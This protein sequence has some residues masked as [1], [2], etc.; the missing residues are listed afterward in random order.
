MNPSS[1]KRVI[2][3]YDGKC[4]FC[5]SVASHYRKVKGHEKVLF[6]NI[7][8]KKFNS[9]RQGLSKKEAEEVIHA[10]LPNG[11]MKLGVDALITLW[12]TFP[13]YKIFAKVFNHSATKPIAQVFYRIIAKYR[14]QIPKFLLR[15]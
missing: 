8:T 4:G 9:Y 14:K 6:I 11:Q 15:K 12:D 3:F 2:F 5:Q 7:H 10:R 1:D 13:N